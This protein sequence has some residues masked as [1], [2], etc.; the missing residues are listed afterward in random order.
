MRIGAIQT[1]ILLLLIGGFAL[2]LTRSPRRYFHIAREIGKEWKDIDRRQLRESIRALYKSKL[3][4]TEYHGDGSVTL[5]LT[6][7]GEKMALRHEVDAL[8][9]PEIPEWDGKW[10]VVLFDVPEA[11][12][13]E[14]DAFS[15]HMKKLGFFQYQKSVF[16]HPSDCAKEIDFLIEY[17][18]L[19]EHVRFIVAES[20]DNEL[21]LKAHFR[22][23]SF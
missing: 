9:L 2:G 17:H 15:F 4:K 22:P 10:R 21:H 7:N 3:V 19:R 12:K 13:K 23:L 16:V 6:R 14:R 20:L 5:V 1:K 11:H 8:E 18:G